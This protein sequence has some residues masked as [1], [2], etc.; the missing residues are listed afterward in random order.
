MRAFVWK[1]VSRSYPLSEPDK[2][3][4]CRNVSAVERKG[5]LTLNPLQFGQPGFEI[6][7]RSYKTFI[8]GDVRL[9]AQQ[10]FRFGNVGLSLLGIIL[11]QI[12]AQHLPDARG[13]DQVYAVLCFKRW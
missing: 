8:E 5:V 7:D 13:R 12:I 9:P 4:R 2:S 3:I 11:R 6:V 1:R 10:V